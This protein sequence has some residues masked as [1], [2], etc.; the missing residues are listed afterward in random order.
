MYI[1]SVLNVVEIWSIKIMI[2]FLG[3]AKLLGYT[4]VIFTSDYCSA[5]F[6]KE[7]FHQL[8]HLQVSGLHASG[9]EA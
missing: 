1:Y 7:P 8:Y 3:Q 4:E 9:I 5:L 6:L 2:G